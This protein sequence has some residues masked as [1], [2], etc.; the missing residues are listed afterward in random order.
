M[1]NF[2]SFDH[3]ST[4]KSKKLLFSLIG[5]ANNRDGIK[6]TFWCMITVVAS[7]SIVLYLPQGGYRADP[8]HGSI[9]EQ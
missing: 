2:R 1:A 9:F 6:I 5:R 3:H 8:N 4:R 7:F